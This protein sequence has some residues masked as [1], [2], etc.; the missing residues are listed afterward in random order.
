MPDRPLRSDA[1]IED[2]LRSV[3]ATDE[4]ARAA[5]VE[6]AAEAGLPD[7]AVSSD[8]GALLAVLASLAGPDERGSRAIVEVGCL[9]G[10]SAICLARGLREGGRLY[11]IEPEPLHAEVAAAEFTRAGIE[12]RVEI[13][14]EPGLDALAKLL[15]RL[16]PASV[17]VLFLDAIKQEYPAYLRVGR[18]L[19]RVGG[20]LMADNVL[21]SSDWAVADPPG[22]SDARD[23]VDSFNRAVAN[24]PGFQAACIANRAGL[25][26]ARRVG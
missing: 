18:P 21:S 13:L 3:F 9:A 20:L 5:L 19:L 24:D 14:R 10:Y 23:A 17:D 15:D 25:L 8:V 16:G 4:P 7:I 26:V 11:T 6:R 1:T 12:D 22:T 2:Y